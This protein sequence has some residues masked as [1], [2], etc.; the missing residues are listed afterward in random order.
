MVEHI[1]VLGYRPLTKHPVFQSRW[2]VS[3]SCAC[4]LMCACPE[5][6]NPGEKLCA[7]TQLAYV[8]TDFVSSRH[9]TLVGVWNQFSVL[10]S[11]FSVLSSQFSVVS[12]CGGSQFSVVSSQFGLISIIL[13]PGF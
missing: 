1:T 13:R 3:R 10:S 4:T 2:I 6:N 8:M 12:S 5:L 11:Q 7:E 9:R